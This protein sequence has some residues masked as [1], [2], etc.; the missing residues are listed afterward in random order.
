MLK[1]DLRSIGMSKRKELSAALLGIAVA[2]ILWV[3][4]L[5]RDSY[6]ENSLVFEPFHAFYS[7]VKDIQD[8]RLRISGNFIGNIILFIPVGVLFP[9]TGDEH[10]CVKTGF[11]ALCFSIII[12]II[13]LVSHRGYFEVDDLILNTLGAVMGYGIYRVVMKLFTKNDLNATGN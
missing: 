10:K 5:G 7:F 3:T 1:R 11:V 9:L 8:G 2:V 12:E 4:V 6:I 13:Q